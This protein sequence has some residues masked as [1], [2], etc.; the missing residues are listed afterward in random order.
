MWT[1]KVALTYVR[2]A[3]RYALVGL[4]ITSMFVYSLPLAVTI[5]SE[6]APNIQLVEFVNSNYDPSNTTIVVLHASRAFEFFGHQFRLVHCGH[7]VRKAVAIIQTDSNS[8]NTVLITNSAV[9]A[10]RKHGIMLTV[11]KVAEF[12]RNPLVNAEDHLVIL[13]RILTI[14]V[15]VKKS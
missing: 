3:A 14:S 9:E 11:T 15:D 2:T 8:S 10:L 5:H 12:S 1:N 7:D 6:Q 13:Y 4:F